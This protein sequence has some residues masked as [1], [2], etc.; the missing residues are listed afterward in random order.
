MFATVMAVG[1]PVVDSTIANIALPSIARSLHASNN[2]V[3]WV[4]N[5]YNL[6]II[7]ALMPAGAFSEIFGYRA[8]CRLGLVLFTA[9]SLL[10]AI[11]P[12]LPVLC[13]A[14][15]LQGLGSAA[16]MTTTGSLMRLNY[17][18]G[19]LGSAMGAH[20]L[21]VA[22][23]SAVGPS[24]GAAILLVA[25]W[26][27]LFAI[28]IP[29]G[30]VSIIAARSLPQSPRAQHVFDIPAALLAS[31]ALGF[32]AIAADGAMNAR[33]PRTAVA[34]AIGA[35]LGWIVVMRSRRSPRPVVPID[36]LRIPLFS[37]SVISSILTFSGLSIGL[38][39]IPFMIQ[40]TWGRTPSV[41][42]A[43]MTAYPACVAV[44]AYAVGRSA[45]RHP[46]RSAIVGLVIF[47]AGLMALA[48][49]SPGP[50]VDLVWR[51][52]LFGL[53][54]GLFQTPNNSLIF[55]SGPVDRS[56][57]AG[58]MLALAR[59]TG[60]TLGAMIFAA[61]LRSPWSGNWRVVLLV[62][63]G[64][65]V[66]AIVTTSVRLGAYGSASPSGER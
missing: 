22:A 23:S 61:M 8:A 3:I 43:L 59:L 16:I 48:F 40:T 20:S 30:V 50:L 27:Y 28:N 24:I 65:A 36:L 66:L 25:P 47:V 4:V 33:W 54:F 64:C 7:V 1:L 11:A 10:C 37:L 46:G 58:S 35:G 12:N 17:G 56:G 2:D 62:G 57:A 53:G 6:A 45:N 52:G 63:A 29:L 15:A 55:S 38:L 31:A 26:P 39:T 34:G 13:V 49:A 19:R 14:R 60:Q 18:P 51:I 32:M 21:A 44:S 9:A 42:G 5:A 41:A